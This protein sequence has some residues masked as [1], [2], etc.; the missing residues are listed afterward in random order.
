MDI[1]YSLITV[2]DYPGP[3]N[4]DD[5]F[6]IMDSKASQTT[7]L[8]KGTFLAETVHHKMPSSVLIRS[9][10]IITNYR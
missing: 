9:A 5:I 7:F 2:I 4:I 6:K 1:F 3:E 8:Q 10:F